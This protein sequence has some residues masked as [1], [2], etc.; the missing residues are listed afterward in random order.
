LPLAP[1]V[2]ERLIVGNEHAF[3]T[4]LYDG[5][6]ARPEAIEP[7]AV[8]EYLRTFAGPTGVLG[9]MGTYR[10]AFTSIEQTEPLIPAKI[11]IPTV[12]MGGR[13][14]R[15]DQTRWCHYA[16]TMLLAC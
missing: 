8:D 9:S 16:R 13:V 6:T 2:P 12:A 5:A 7:E 10:A 11:A 14:I 4:C 15:P 1:G 3:Q